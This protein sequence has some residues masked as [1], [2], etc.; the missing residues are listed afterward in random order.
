[1]PKQ[2]RRIYRQPSETAG[3][4]ALK[5]ACLDYF[6]AYEKLLERPSRRYAERARRALRAMRKFAK[7]R[8]REILSLYSDVQNIGRE[9]IYGHHDKYSISLADK[10][11]SKIKK[12]ETND[13]RT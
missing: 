13:A 5:R 12:E 7:H 10:Q 3:H 4:L 9:P 1:M 6:N 11:N 2:V 8:G